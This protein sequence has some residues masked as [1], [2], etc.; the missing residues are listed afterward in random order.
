MTERF[1]EEPEK[2]PASGCVDRG[3]CEA[4]TSRF[5]GLSTCPVL[6]TAREGAPT[7]LGVGVVCVVSGLILTSYLA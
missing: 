2:K 4:T 3:G 6:M 7:T 5:W 1:K